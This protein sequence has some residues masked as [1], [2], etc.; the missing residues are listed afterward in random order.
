[1]TPRQVVGC[2]LGD[3]IV[4]EVL[5]L[6]EG[7]KTAGALNDAKGAGSGFETVGNGH[8]NRLLV[9]GE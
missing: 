9:L 2:L 5:V 7:V 8:G 6:E 1:M 3:R 4:A